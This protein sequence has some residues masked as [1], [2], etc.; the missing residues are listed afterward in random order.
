MDTPLNDAKAIWQAGVDAVMSD[1]LV[2]DHVQVDGKW[3]LLGD[4]PPIDL[5]SIRRL[6]VV[7]AGKAGL[8]MAR[9][10]ESAL[11]D[12][13]QAK[14]LNGWVNVPA[15][16]VQRLK[17][18][19]LHPARPAG[20][21]EPTEEGVRGTE[22]I[23]RM[24]SSLC[25]EQD[26]CFCVISGGGS[27]LLPAPAKGITLE[28]K[29]W[30]TQHLSGAGAN[31][32]Q[33]NTVRKQLSQVKGGRL[34]AAC[35]AGRLATLIISDVIGDPL[36]VIASG[37]TVPDTATPQ[38]AIAV[39]QEFDAVGAGMPPDILEF[40]HSADINPPTSTCEVTTQVI[41]N[42]AS[43][44]DAAGVEAEKRGFS[45]AMVA[46]NKLEGAAEDVGLHLLKMA[47]QMAADP[48]GPDCLITGGE[49]VVRLA[50]AAIRGK[51][52]R[53]Q[54]LVLAALNEAARAG[55][56]LSRITILAGGTDGEDGPTDA[57]GAWIDVA[58]LELTRNKELNAS[59]YL[60]RNDAYNFFEQTETL[61]KTGATNTN[62]C[63]LRVVVIK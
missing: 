13:A 38:D 48:D 45:H 1:R 14:E 19:T 53:N 8:G 12:W 2:T 51:G 49:P 60:A 11:G 16:C 58:T 4:E 17:H 36:D 15:D 55:I 50:D 27:A 20:L 24:L 44:V 39:L 32:Q 3:L 54:Q 30:I 41:G 59:D 43:A 25:E 9:G 40:L 46:T 42:N 56:D 34:A 28:Q 10:L 57:A 33:L 5:E 35:K 26:L 52:G 61:L 37:P 63:D 7:G 29:Q 21:N 18:I 6:F 62:V 31:I 47:R 23:L 22:M